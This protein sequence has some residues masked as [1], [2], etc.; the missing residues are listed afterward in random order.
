MQGGAEGSVAA[1]GGEGGLEGLQLEGEVLEGAALAAQ[2]KE[3]L[4]ELQ[5][6]SFDATA[7]RAFHSAFNNMSGGSF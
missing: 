6:G 7:A 5:L 2:Y 3:A 4:Q 1:E